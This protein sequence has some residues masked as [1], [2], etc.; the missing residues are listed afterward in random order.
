MGAHV[1]SHPRV[2]QGGMGAAISGWPLA[3]AVAQ[4]GQLGVVSGTALEIVCT[5]RLQRGDPGG[6]IRRALAHFPFP[7]VTERILGSYFVAS[8]IA[9]GKPFR[10]VLRFTLHPARALAELV[11]AANF[12]EVFLAKE[13]HDGLIGINYLRKIE[14]PMPYACYGAMLAGVDHIIVGAGNPA[15]IPSL[16]SRL[17]CHEPAALPVKVQGATS[18]DGDYAV[19]FDPA[20][21][22]AARR[23]PIRRPHFD[24]IVASADLARALAADEAARPDGFIIEGHAAGGHNAPPRGPRRLDASGQPIYDERDAVRPDEIA[25]IGLPFWMAGSYGTPAGLARALAGGACGV[26]V[27]TAFALCRESGLA[28][29]C[30]QRL[31][32]QAA[33]GAVRVRTDPRASPTGFPFKVAELDGT[34]SGSDTY[35]SR[36]RLCDL[37]VL[38]S[39]YRK[40]DGTI[41]YRCPAEPVATYE[42]HGGRLQN[43]ADRRCLCNALLATAGLGQVRAN[44]YAEPPIVTMGTDFTAVKELLRRQPAG[45][46]GYTAAEVISYLLSEP[47][48]ERP[49]HRGGR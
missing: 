14:L 37:G 28:D 48:P 32:A 7:E 17:A 1:P 24:A 30:K 34:L 41:G 47:P 49:G 27:G 23:P 19:E 11:V 5:R 29:D 45:E 43:T 2:I 4:A 22:L 15:E 38:R 9:A 31:L 3:R 42:R 12:A 16:L 13:G 36:P 39:A 18:A 44:G 25:E 33:R 20:E 46:L 21:L 35:A 8:G 6:H 10:P 26:Q 40:P